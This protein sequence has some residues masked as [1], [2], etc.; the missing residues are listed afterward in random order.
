MPFTNTRVVA[1]ARKSE[2]TEAEL[3]A[4]EARFNAMLDASPEARVAWEEGRR[5]LF[6][7]IAEGNKRLKDA[8]RR[9]GFEGEVTWPLLMKAWREM[10][11]PVEN[12]AP[13]FFGH[14]IRLLEA[15]ATVLEQTNAGAGPL[16]EVLK[17]VTGMLGGRPVQTCEIYGEKVKAL[18]GHQSQ[19]AFRRIV[20]LSV[21]VQQ[22]A[23]GGYASEKTIKAYCA[24][25]A[26]MAQ[27]LTPEKLKKTDRKK[28]Q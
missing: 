18:R 23:E 4:F 2:E 26:K 1:A 12:F 11:M 28:R 6:D 9:A 15:R 21:D 19:K 13:A 14:L 22:R 5:A 10:G 16:P 20:R 27:N 7:V 17:A 24:Y 25:A 8:L 3:K